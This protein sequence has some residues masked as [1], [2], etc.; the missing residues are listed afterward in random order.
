MLAL[1]LFVT[2]A[3]ARYL[4]LTGGAIQ[5]LGRCYVGNGLTYQKVE[6]NG[7]FLNSFTSNDCDNWLPTG[8][9]LVNYPVV[10]SLYDYIAVKY[11]YDKKGCENTVD[12]AKPTEQLYTDVC[13]SLGV[14][15]TRYAIE[16]NKLVLKT[17]TNTDCTGTFTLSVESE[18]LDKCVDKSTYSYKITS[19]AFEVFAL[20]A[21]A[22]A[23]LF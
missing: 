11:S 5:K 14:G 23:F 13:T 8:S 17:F 2:I 16:G 10:Y 12:K 9:S 3:S 22:L 20:L 6:L 15:S 4:V 19:G 7:Y 1:L 18:E 21:L